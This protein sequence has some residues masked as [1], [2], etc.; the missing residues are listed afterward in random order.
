MWPASL[1]SCN[2][3]RIT[4]NCEAVRCRLMLMKELDGALLVA[5][6]PDFWPLWGEWGTGAGTDMGLPSCSGLSSL[7]H[8]STPAHPPG[9]PYKW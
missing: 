8:P 2:G 7:P 3:G 9:A 6:F 1:P 5:L 4:V